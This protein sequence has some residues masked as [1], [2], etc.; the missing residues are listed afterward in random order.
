MAE[1]KPNT[2]HKFAFTKRAIEAL[3]AH[4]PASKSRDAEY[5]DAEC[6]GLHARVSKGGRKFFQHRYRHLGRKQCMSLGEFPAVSVQDAR[7]RVAENKALLARDKDPV[8]ERDK[9]RTELTFEQ[10][11][12]GHYLPH[13]MAHKLTWTDD[14]TQ[15]ERQLVPAL[16][17]LRL[18]AITPRDVELTHAREKE[19]TSACTANHLLTTVKRM[20]NL[21]VKWGMLEKSPAAGVE[22]FNEGPL[23]ERYLSKGD[24]LPR[25]LKALDE[26]DD[27]LS[28]AAIRLLLYT[29][30]RR[31]EVVSLT[32]VQVRL[33]EGRLHLPL[34]KNGGSRSVHLN[35]KARELLVDLLAK[36]DA[37]EF[38]RRSEYVF[39]SRAGTKRGYIY[40]L[41]KPFAR[42]CKAAG[43]NGFRV[44]DMRHT[45]ATMAVSSGS[46][47][48]RVQ[49][50]LGHK[51]IA[52]TLR[53]AHLAADDLKSATEGVSDLFELA[54]A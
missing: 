50:L 6:V 42:A 1:Y 36:R 29:G 47:L 34:T 41:R 4:D 37:D 43:I 23:R 26:E 45:F 32:W 53:Y 27:K 51:D 7:Q 3:P 33:D 15:I 17:R 16:G 21:A 46:D 28:V 52:S 54:A 49:H 14:R 39:P 10:F 44:H 8:A 2:S 12:T 22:K 5:A 11:A 40:D 38:T 13:A 25:F 20:L 30:C 19:R 48:F 18:S 31:K 24:E 9:V 35:A